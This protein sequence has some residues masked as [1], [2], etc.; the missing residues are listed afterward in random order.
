MVNP[1]LIRCAAFVLSVA[2]A[3][4]LRAQDSV[5]SARA[6]VRTAAH[7]L[8]TLDP[9]DPLDDLAPIG[10]LVAG[11]RVIG[12]GESEHYVHEFLT[13][14]ARLLRYLVE[15]HGVTALTFEAGM[16]EALRLTRWVAGEG[17]EPDFAG[18]L[19]FNGTG[20]Y[21][22]LQEALRWLRAHNEK[23]PPARRVRFYGVDLANGGGAIR[24]VLDVLWPYLRRVDPDA[25]RTFRARLDG[26]ADRFGINWP[27][28]AHEKYTQL[29]E[30]DRA[31]LPGA[32][33]DLGAHLRRHRAR[34]LRAAPADDYEIAVRLVA[35][36]DQT[37][38]FIRIPTYGDANPRDSALAE[39]VRWVLD[40][41]GGRGKVLVWAHNAHVQ[42][43]G[44]HVPAMNSKPVLSM[45]QV[46]AAELGGGYVALGTAFGRRAADTSGADPTTFDGLLASLGAPLFLVNLADAPEWFRREQRMRFQTVEIRLVPAAAFDAVVFVERTTPGRRR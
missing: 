7:P 13:L 39:N 43:V 3:G 25:E 26:I 6:W 45:G 23:V 40:R 1:M 32:I 20:G 31:E 44:I 21:A 17:G 37:E 15:R 12:S 27:R 36:L 11:A 4:V 33:R 29:T 34:Y 24:P 22:E 16:A 46:L 8:T 41:E 19:P 18:G 9:A 42:R 38:R 35:V 14:R 28:A 5:A 2:S 10:R 30:V